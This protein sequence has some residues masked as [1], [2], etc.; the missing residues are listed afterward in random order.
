MSN[1]VM[2]D[3]ETLGTKP[4]CVVLT[5]G[6]VKFSPYNMIEPGPGLYMRLDVDEQTA[7]GRSVDE[8]TI[9]W[10]GKQKPDVREEALG[11]GPDRVK[12]ET[13]IAD[14]NRF[15]VGVKNIWAQGPLLDIVVLENIYRQCERPVPWWYYKVR[16]SRTVFAMHGDPRVRGKEG[17]HNALEDCVSQA[18]AVQTVYKRLGITDAK[19]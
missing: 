13:M 17:L 7:R 19:P 18:V 12:M 16:D 5:L 9:A 2:I 3:I 1:S 11:E 10:W 8:G 15:L 4:D 14:L 6:A